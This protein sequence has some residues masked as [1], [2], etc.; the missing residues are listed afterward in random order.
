MNYQSE[1]QQAIQN[2][3]AVTVEIKSAQ[4]QCFVLTAGIKL[5]SKEREN[6]DEQ[7]NS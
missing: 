6:G 4:V 5:K 1:W 3:S 2:I 7:N